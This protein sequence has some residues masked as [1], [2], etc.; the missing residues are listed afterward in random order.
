MYEQQLIRKI[1]ACTGAIKRGDKAPNQTDAP[2]LLNALKA[3]NLPMYEE[4]L[5]NYK[6]AVATYEE[7][8]S[9]KQ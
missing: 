1:T 9:K 2:K 5:E 6:V 4:L 8:Q 3:I 7:I